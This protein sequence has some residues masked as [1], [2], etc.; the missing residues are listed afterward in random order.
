M[1]GL[2]ASKPTETFTTVAGLELSIQGVE[3]VS[4]LFVKSDTVVSNDKAVHGGDF[5]EHVNLAVP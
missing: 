4:V 2:E 5:V 1:E 3:G